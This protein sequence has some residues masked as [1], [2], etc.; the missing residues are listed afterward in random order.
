MNENNK[1]YTPEVPDEI[2]KYKVLLFKILFHIKTKYS[3]INND[4]NPIDEI[5]DIIIQYNKDFFDIPATSKLKVNVEP[6]TLTKY[7]KK[8]VGVINSNKIVLPKSLIDDYLIGKARKIDKKIKSE[9]RKA[10]TKK[11][12]KLRLQSLSD[13]LE[14]MNYSLTSYKDT[15]LI[16]MNNENF[17][18]NIHLMNIS[19]ISNKDPDKNRK[20]E[21]NEI[22][23]FLKKNQKKVEVEDI[24]QNEKM[25]DYINLMTT[26]N[27][28]IFNN[29]FKF[30][31]LDDP[32]KI[33]ELDS[34][35]YKFF[36]FAN[37]IK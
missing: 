2:L 13:V 25:D 32:I 18:K 10:K 27:N 11:K 24:E 14:L 30:N 34:I 3:D 23:E 6:I 15:L 31:S 12:N 26:S 20:N 9:K 33:E 5:K 17:Y 36:N 1:S 37:R 8:I 22:Y 28:D 29:T 4:S 16:E 19:T 7:I 35:G 21:I